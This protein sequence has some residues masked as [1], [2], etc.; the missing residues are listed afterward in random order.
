MAWTFGIG[1]WWRECGWPVAKPRQEV[2]RR[3]NAARGPQNSRFPAG[4][5]A[6]CAHGCSRC[7]VRLVHYAGLHDPQYFLVEADD[8]A[9]SRSGPQASG[10]PGAVA[11]EWLA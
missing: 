4:D 2:A 9:A 5:D 1:M 3:R 10:P 11:W 6:T 8:R 7:G